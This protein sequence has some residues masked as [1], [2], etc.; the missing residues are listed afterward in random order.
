[1]DKKKIKKYAGISVLTA[2]LIT[3][4]L[5]FIYEE[6]LDHTE[7]D[8][9]FSKIFGIDHQVIQIEKEE[10]WTAWKVYDYLNQVDPHV[11][12]EEDLKNPNYGILQNGKTIYGSDGIEYN[13]ADNVVIARKYSKKVLNKKNVDLED[14]KPIKENIIFTK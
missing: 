4:G 9:F 6:N 5:G 13:Y 2:S 14:E 7:E 3:G 10:G 11:S 1:M 8:C 12:D